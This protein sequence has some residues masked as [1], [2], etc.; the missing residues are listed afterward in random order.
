MILIPCF[1]R[2]AELSP[3]SSSLL[4]DWLDVSGN[5]SQADL[6]ALDQ[7]FGMNSPMAMSYNEFNSSNSNNSS[8]AHWG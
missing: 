8:N 7:D 6:D 3:L 4:A 5:I 1:S 2:L